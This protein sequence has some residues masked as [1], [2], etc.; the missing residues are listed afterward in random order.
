MPQ[1]LTDVKMSSFQVFLAMVMT[2]YSNPSCLDGP[3]V[4]QACM[5]L[6]PPHFYFQLLSILISEAACVP[7]FRFLARTEA[8]AGRL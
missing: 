4:S 6:P 7:H 1:V 3:E 8:F 2:R 5:Y